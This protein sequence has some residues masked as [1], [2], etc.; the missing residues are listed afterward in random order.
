M[1]EFYNLPSGVVK[2]L[3]QNHYLKEKVLTPY[4]PLHLLADNLRKEGITTTANTSEEN[5]YDK[6]WW[7]TMQD[8]K[9]TWTAAVT[10]GSNDYNQY[11]L[12]YGLQVAQK[13]LVVLDRLSFLEPAAKRRKFLQTNQL[14]KMIVL[15]PRPKFRAIGST[16]DSVT[17]CWFIFEKG[18]SQ[19]GTDIVYALD[20]DAASPLTPLT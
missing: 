20:W 18:V 13:G 15:S 6:N 1:S 5:L 2:V 19:R 8:Q 16:R 4:D 7:S 9:H 11:I 17:A 10:I 14:T 3:T 12:E